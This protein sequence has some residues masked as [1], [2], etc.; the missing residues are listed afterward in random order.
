MLMYSLTAAE[1]TFVG[2]SV[3]P[4]HFVFTV[5]CLGIL[6]ILDGEPWTSPWP[7]T[8]NLFQLRTEVARNVPSEITSAPTPE[9]VKG[10]QQAF[11]SLVNSLRNSRRLHRPQR[12]SKLCSARR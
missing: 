12:R 4:S 11:S 6:R 5:T 2:S 7:D 8:P 3:G 10:A 9:N 1:D